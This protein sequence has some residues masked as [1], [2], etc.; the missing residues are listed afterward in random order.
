MSKDFWDIDV[1]LRIRM[2]TMKEYFPHKKV[3][4]KLKKMIEIYN[5]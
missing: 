4:F 1:Q 2:T 3:L 5:K